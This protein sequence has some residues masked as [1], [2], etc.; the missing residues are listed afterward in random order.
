VSDTNAHNEW[1]QAVAQGLIRQKEC[2]EYWATPVHTHTA[3][4]LASAMRWDGMGCNAMCID[5]T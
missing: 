3:I 2:K 1:K 4:P 5:V